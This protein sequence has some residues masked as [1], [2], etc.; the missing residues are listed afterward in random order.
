MLCKL[1]TISETTIRQENGRYHIRHCQ[2][3]LIKKIIFS[4]D[5]GYTKK[6]SLNGSPH[7]LYKK[8]CHEAPHIRLFEWLLSFGTYE[9]FVFINKI[10][11]QIL[12]RLKFFLVLVKD[13]AVR[14]SWY[15]IYL[16]GCISI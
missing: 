14:I 6:T 2:K 13:R 9:E 15:S 12:N 16:S 1:K 8:S 5:H 4:F 3:G 7:N 10:V 11:D